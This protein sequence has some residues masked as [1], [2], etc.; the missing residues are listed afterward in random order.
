MS[1]TRK[2]VIV[3]GAGIVGSSITYHLSQAGFQVTLF[4]QDQ[5]AS[6]ATAHAFGW[7]TQAIAE[8]AADANLRK[9]AIDD[10]HRLE[11]EIPELG[12]RWQGSITYT[13]ASQTCLTG[14]ARL[15]STQITQLEP[16]LLHP[17]TTARFMPGDGA[18]DAPQATRLLIQHACQLG[19]I[20]HEQTPV[21]ALIQENGITTAVQTKRGRFKADYIVLACGTGITTL[22]NTIQLTIPIHSSPAI[23]LR[24]HSPKNVVNTILSGD[25]FEVRQAKNGN[26][27]AA[28]DY[29]SDKA[30][31]DIA[32]QAQKLIKNGLSGTENITLN[33]A[34]IGYRPIPKD[35]QPIIGF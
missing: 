23:L 7:I 35:G 15:D 21:L 9:I 17:P 24:F 22:L 3:I 13:Q 2:Q 26:L 10:W 28:E 11:K 34:S 31:D 8:D 1:N 6:A 4:E 5:P 14:E 12:I 29:I 18:I 27:I 19:A 16:A 20:F 30:L 25:D 33:H 32:H